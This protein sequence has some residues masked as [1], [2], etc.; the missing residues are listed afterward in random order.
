MFCW[1]LEYHFS[2]LLS[3]NKRSTNMTLSF[4][5]VWQTGVIT[6]RG[7]WRVGSYTEPAST[8][9]GP[10]IHLSRCS[11]SGGEANVAGWER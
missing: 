10:C 6:E 8:P 4:T 3:K 1:D 7:G 9:R 11:G 2:A 5:A